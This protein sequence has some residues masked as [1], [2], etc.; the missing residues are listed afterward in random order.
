MVI[1]I[2]NVSFSDA[3]RYPF[4]R[5]KRLIYALFLLIP[6]FGWLILFGYLARLVNEFIEGR[7]EGPIKLNIMD[8]MSLGFTIFLKSLPF[9]IVYVILISAVSYVSETIGILLNLLLSFFIIPILQVNFYRKQTIESYFEFDILNIVKDNLGSYV[10]AIL[11]QYAL[12]IIFLVLSVVLIG[13]PALIFTGA[14]FTANFYGKCTEAKNIFVSKPEY[15]DQ[16]PV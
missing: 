15:E 4:K 2:E 12:A 16:V 7:Y 3:F 9:I 13:I 8:D 11:K 14:I 1:I 10:V 6:I 5:P